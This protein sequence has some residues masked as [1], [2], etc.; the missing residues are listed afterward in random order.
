MVG[1]VI[2]DRVNDLLTGKT[3][4][5]IVLDFDVARCVRDGVIREVTSFLVIRPGVAV[6]NVALLTNDILVEDTANLVLAK[7]A[8][9]V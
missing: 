5:N 1:T 4:I 3:G 2:E 9:L 6:T 7:E 8:V